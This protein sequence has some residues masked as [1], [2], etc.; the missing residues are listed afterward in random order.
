MSSTPK[1]P[2]LPVP[3]DPQ[4]KTAPREA[5]LLDYCPPLTPVGER[6]HQA[7]HNVPLFVRYPDGVHLWVS[8]ERTKSAFHM[9]LFRKDCPGVPIHTVGKPFLIVDNTKL[10]PRRR[11]PKHLRGETA[12]TK[13]S[14]HPLCSKEE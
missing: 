5:T 7:R 2:A 10:R 12:T 4:S 1:G 11:L 3:G 8:E 9:E 6:V 14:T 13:T